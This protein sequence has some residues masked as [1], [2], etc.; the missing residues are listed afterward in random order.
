MYCTKHSNHNVVTASLETLLQ[1]LRTPPPALLSVLL[2]S[3]GITPSTG[4]DILKKGTDAL[5]SF[6]LMLWMCKYFYFFS[7]VV[8]LLVTTLISNQL[9][10]GTTIRKSLLLNA[11]PRP[12]ATAC[13]HAMHY[14][15]FNWAFSFCQ[16]LHESINSNPS[17][18]HSAINICPTPA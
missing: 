9:S 1:L 16:V 15:F 3:E 17:A 14:D 2:S 10:S 12:K 4:S 8:A 13:T 11:P 6:V 18:L 5:Y 7:A